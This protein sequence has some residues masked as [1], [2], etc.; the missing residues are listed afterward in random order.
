MKALDLIEFRV[1]TICGGRAPSQLPVRLLVKDL[2]QEGLANVIIKG[3]VCCEIMGRTQARREGPKSV[4]PSSG[5]GQ[6]E[7]WAI[8]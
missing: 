5:V 8:W 4:P 6:N 7:L 3:L 2:K 1:G